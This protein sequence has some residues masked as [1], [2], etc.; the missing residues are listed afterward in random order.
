[1]NANSENESKVP[2]GHVYDGIQEYDNPLPGWWTNLFWGTCIFSV[3]YLVYYHMGAEGRSVHDDFDQHMAA[4]M[5]QRFSKIGDLEGDRATI[6]KYMKDPEWLPVG[7]NVFRTNC[8]SCHGDQGQGL[9]GPNL[10]DDNWKTV[11]KVEDLYTV[12]S[13][14]AAN[15]AMPAWKRRLTHKNQIVLAAAYI[16]SLRE[17]SPVGGKAPEG[18]P[19]PAWE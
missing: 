1:M 12:I 19:I 14:G 10:T 18:D 7:R 8:V 17:T 4:V 2:V 5:V 6:L 13:D 16:A 9:I 11:K 15:G 3:F